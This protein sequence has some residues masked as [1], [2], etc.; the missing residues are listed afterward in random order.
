MRLFLKTLSRIGGAVLV[1][2]GAVFGQTAQQQGIANTTQ[3]LDTSVLFA[4]GAREAEQALRGSFGWPTFQ[5]G[6]VD[7]VY[8]RFDPDGYARFSTSPRL[9]EDVFEVICAESSTACVARKQGFE[10]GLTNEG[11]VQ[12]QISGI[13]PQDTFFVSDRKSELPLPPTVL[14]PLDARMETL[15]ASSGHLIV[16]RELEKINEFSLSGFSAVSTYLR[17]VAQGQS[18]R[19]FPRGWPAPAQVQAQN[20]GGLTQPGVWETPSAGP[21][22]VQT[23]F[24]Q[25][26]SR[27]SQQ[28]GGQASAGVVQGGFNGGAVVNNSFGIGAQQQFGGAQFAPVGSSDGGMEQIQQMVQSLQQELAQLR[29]EKEQGFQSAA[30]NPN[31]DFAQSF[32]QQAQ[33]RNLPEPLGYGARIE[34]NPSISNDPVDGFEAQK[35]QSYVNAPSVDVRAITALEQRLYALEQ[36]VWQMNQSFQAELT[37]LSWARQAD[38][39]PNQTAPVTLPVPSEA[40][41]MDALERLLVERLGAREPLV[42]VEATPTNLE[43]NG[44]QS[45]ERALVLDLLDQLGAG[46][47]SNQTAQ[48][49]QSQT[50]ETD[51]AGD[52]ISLADYLNDVLKSET[53]KAQAAQ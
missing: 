32:A 34:Q 18:P 7:R 22:R 37:K 3:I 8:F 1:S 49:A 13:T 26:P 53:Q 16:K 47:A 19:V 4:I 11:K 46:Q 36:S 17:W 6:F 21:Q 9:D 20:V 10:V 30:A 12:L 29:N 27:A 33:A 31:E 44:A 14:E 42:D 25:W 51:T 45:G 15:L 35:T 50:E 23:T 28:N 2:A 39:T 43:Q 40:A 41:R 24:R 48:E 52:Y 38:A 5:E